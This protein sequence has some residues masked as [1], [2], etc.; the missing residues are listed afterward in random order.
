MIVKNGS[1]PHLRLTGRQNRTSL[2]GVHRALRSPHPERAGRI[3]CIEPSESPATS[4][5]STREF[6]CR[7]CAEQMSY[8]KLLDQLTPAELQLD[9]IYLDPNNPRFT[10]SAWQYIPDNQIPLGPVQEAT[11]LRL[12]KEFG[13]GRLRMNMEVNGFLPIDRVVVRE[14]ATGQ[15]VV[16]EGNRRICAAKLITALTPEGE[17]VPERVLTS[18]ATIP[19]LLYT[20]TDRDVSWIIQGLRHITGLADWSSF[21]KAKLLV[22]QMEA[23]GL[24]QTAVGK[25]FG[26]T[27]HGA[28]QWLRGYFAFQQAKDRSDYVREVDER[29]YPYLQELFSRSSIRVREWMKWDDSD[30]EFKDELRFNEFVGWFYPRPEADSDQAESEAL[31][32]WE[33]RVITRQDDIRQLPYLL[34]TDPESFEHFRREL[35]LEAAYASALLKEQSSREIYDPVEEVFGSIRSCTRALDHL[36]F[37]L[38]REDSAKEQLTNALAPLEQAIAAIKEAL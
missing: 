32:D 31:G 10:G 13:V 30:R 33:K 15:Y 20:G 34:T 27:P 11:R 36:P 26:L 16:V 19:C 29:V 6:D 7:G 21:N 3:A 17:A 2:R 22:E 24:T 4:T 28:G 37:K 5:T 8:E 25:R 14:F 23:E 18:L 1:W 9:A 12:I 38:L 35:D